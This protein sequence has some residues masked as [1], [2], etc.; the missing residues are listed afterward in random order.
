MITYCPQCA[1][2][3]SHSTSVGIH[4]DTTKLSWQVCQAT[5]LR[6]VTRLMSSID[7]QGDSHMHSSSSEDNDS[8][9]MFPNDQQQ[10]QRPPG[11]NLVHSSELSPPHSQ[12]ALGSDRVLDL[13]HNQNDAMDTDVCDV[14]DDSL[15][16]DSQKE[17]GDAQ[18]SSMSAEQLPVDSYIS[19]EH[20]KKAE[21]GWAWKNRKARDEYNRA[22]ENVI[23]KNFSLSEYFLQVSYKPSCSDRAP[24]HYGDPFDDGEGSQPQKT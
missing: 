19:S 14:L 10:E 7:A 22:M 17:L 18:G 4:L 13:G 12:E 23:D 16:G 3:N 2:T 21:P 11:S 1:Q 20:T 8:D 6:S 24:E 9:T 5:M 15:F